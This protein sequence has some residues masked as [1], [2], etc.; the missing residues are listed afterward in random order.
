MKAKK[1]T[2]KRST[3]KKASKKVSH[4]G[5]VKGL[6]KVSKQSRTSYSVRPSNEIVQFGKE[7]AALFFSDREVEL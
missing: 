2:A 7:T 6:G 3:K 1:S 4:F 5:T